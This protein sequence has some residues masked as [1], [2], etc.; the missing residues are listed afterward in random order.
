MNKYLIDENDLKY[1]KT[2]LA[3]SGYTLGVKILEL[4]TPI[5]PM[6]DDLVMDATR[7]MCREFRWPSTALDIAHAIEQHHFGSL[8]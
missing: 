4:L 1:I 2:L 8:E 3:G 7:D 6:T 5:K